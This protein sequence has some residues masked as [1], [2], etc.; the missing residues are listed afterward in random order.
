VSSTDADLAAVSTI[1]GICEIN[2]QKS[3]EK[4]KGIQIPNVTIVGTHAH[5][6]RNIVHSVIAN[7]LE[8][9][10]SN[11]NY[12]SGGADGS[13]NLW[14]FNTTQS[15]ATYRSPGTPAITKLHL[16]ASGSKFGATDQSGNVALW[17]FDASESSLMPFLNM[18]CHTKRANDFAFLN[19]GSVIATC[20]HSLS[21][22]DVKNVCIWDVL[23]SPHKALISS[24][25]GPLEG[26]SCLAY[27]PIRNLLVC[28]AKKGDIYLYDVRERKLLNVIK[29][30]QGNCKT[31]AIDPSEQVCISGSTDG[32]IKI[33][34][35]ENNFDLKDTFANVHK[36]HTFV[37]PTEILNR[38]AVS[39]YGVMAVKF[40]SNYFASAGSDGRL[41]LR[42]WYM[43]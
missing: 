20:G 43:S 17:R 1:G 34:N 32:S 9:H 16:N 33:W 12:I 24:F 28:G 36:Q 39:T 31:L 11:P 37:R 15:L 41:L 30:H 8:S 27:S 5:D 38:T 25:T 14:Q 35:I 26:G 23:V 2:V 22:K 6:K 13:I 19:S 18:Q 10:P 7:W 40:G 21:D 29:A 3:R 4:V 42:K